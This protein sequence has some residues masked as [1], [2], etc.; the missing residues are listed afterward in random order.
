MPQLGRFYKNLITLAMTG[1]LLLG[2]VDIAPA[3]NKESSAAAL[4]NHT[5]STPSE[6]HISPENP[7]T[8]ATVDEEDGGGGGNTGNA[9][10]SDPD[11]PV[12]D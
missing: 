10:P 7:T 12:T 6:E 3:A 8:P 1:S 4:T 2:P 9:V 5:E 11:N